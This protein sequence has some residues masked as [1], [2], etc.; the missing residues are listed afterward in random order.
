MKCLKRILALSLLV[1]LIVPLG[2][3]KPKL[4][5]TIQEAEEVVQYFE[6]PP[7][8][9]FRA[10]KEAL[11][12]RGYSIK[13]DD[14]T[15]LSLETFWQ[16][17]TADSHYVNVFGRRDYGTVGSYYRLA[18]KVSA[19]GNGSRVGITNVAKSIISNLKSSHREE[20]EV[21]LKVAD[22]TRKKDI[23]V[24]NIGLQK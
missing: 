7:A 11:V 20:D 5:G 16:P 15:N 21:F 1:G 23:Q 17:S 24:T 13:E 2:C 9:A 19:Q 18:V 3:S 12:F 8:E 6:A 22:F 4:F 10:T 14:E